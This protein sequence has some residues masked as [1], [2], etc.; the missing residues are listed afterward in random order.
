MAEKLRTGLF[1]NRRYRERPRQGE[2]RRPAKGNRPQRP[3]P[4]PN[5]KPK[6]DALTVALDKYL[7]KIAALR[8]HKTLL[9]YSLA[10]KSFVHSCGCRTFGQVTKSTLEN[11]TVQMKAEGLNDRTVAVRLAYVVTF[12]RAHG[13]TGVTLRHPYTEKK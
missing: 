7:G 12:L 9:A 4:A 6:D 5:P 1:V 8:S 3:G 10:L 13:V 11:F 2:R